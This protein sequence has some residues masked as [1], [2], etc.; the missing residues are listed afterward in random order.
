MGFKQESP[1]SIHILSAVWGTD[2]RETSA[3]AR[4][5]VGGL[6]PKSRQRMMGTVALTETELEKSER[7][8][9]T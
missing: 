2:F 9:W 1:D 5:P 3:V 4:R 7:D 8:V 6:P